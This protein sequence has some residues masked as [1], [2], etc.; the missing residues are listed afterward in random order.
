MVSSSTT[1]LSSKRRVLVS[2]TPCAPPFSLTHFNST[3]NDARTAWTTA[4]SSW[5]VAESLWSR[6]CFQCDVTSTALTRGVR[7]QA[8]ASWTLRRACRKGFAIMTSFTTRSTQNLACKTHNRLTHFCLRR[9]DVSRADFTV[10]ASLATGR[11]SDE[12][13]SCDEVHFALSD[14][15]DCGCFFVFRVKKL[16]EGELR[17]L[18]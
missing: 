16:G 9:G 13:G 3:L 17:P 2:A 10:R 1:R 15:P 4:A 11:F 12:W 18:A 14:H 6:Y 5:W 8:G 7:N